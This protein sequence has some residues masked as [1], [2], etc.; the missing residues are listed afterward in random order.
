M[1]LSEQR[2]HINTSGGSLMQLRRS[3]KDNPKHGCKV[4]EKET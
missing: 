4:Q 3:E 1:S 2:Y